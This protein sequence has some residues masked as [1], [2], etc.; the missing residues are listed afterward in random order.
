MPPAMQQPTPQTFDDLMASGSDLI[1]M[2][3]LAPHFGAFVEEPHRPG[4][5]AQLLSVLWMCSRLWALSLLTFGLTSPLLLLIV[6]SFTLVGGQVCVLPHG[7]ATI[8]YTVFGGLVGG[9]ALLGP[10][11]WAYGLHKQF[12]VSFGVYALLKISTDAIL[13]SQ[14]VKFRMQLGTAQIVL[15][16]LVGGTYHFRCLQGTSV[17]RAVQHFASFVCLVAASG[18]TMHFVFRIIESLA[19]LYA[20]RLLVHPL[21]YWLCIR[22]CGWLVAYG[23]TNAQGRF[24]MLAVPFVF[25]ITKCYIGRYVSNQLPFEQFVVANVVLAVLELLQYMT[26]PLR[27]RILKNLW[28]AGKAL[29]KNAAPRTLIHCAG[30]SPLTAHA[31]SKSLQRASSSRFDPSSPQCSSDNPLTR[32]VVPPAQE[33]ISPASQESRAFTKP[34]ASGLVPAA[35]SSCPPAG[36]LLVDTLHV[37]TLLADVVL[38]PLVILQSSA[39]KLLFFW[40]H[41]VED[42]DYTRIAS[43][44]AVLLSVQA[45]LAICIIWWTRYRH[46]LSVPE[47]TQNIGFRRCVIALVCLTVSVCLTPLRSMTVASEGLDYSFP[48]C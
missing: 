47:I 14:Q 25:L 6:G 40:F 4:V 39:C 13:L 22:V 32:S 21:W 2:P 11:V 5:S 24:P 35:Q 26:Y 19:F 36:E 48:I 12:L 1:D 41:N 15:Y 27:R 10:L 28:P 33:P 37:A 16:W 30:A 31:C 38:E 8:A 42:P 17:C 3:D 43:E 46:N 29:P 18:I 9:A 23:W 44:T 20:Y 45:L 7:A 34:L